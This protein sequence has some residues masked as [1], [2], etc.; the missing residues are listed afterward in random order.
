[1]TPDAEILNG[2]T[3]VEANESQARPEPA[4]RRAML[5]KAGMFLGAS[6]ALAALVTPANATSEGQ[7][8]G[9]DEIHGLWL[10]VVSAPDNSFP[11]F[12]VLELYGSGLYIGS[13]QPDMTPAALSSSLWAIYQRVGPRTFSLSGRFWTYDPSANPTGFAT[14][15]QVAVVSKDGKSYHAKGYAQFF[16]LNSNPLGPP[17]LQYDDGNRLA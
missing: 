9:P 6:S 14:V 8:T 11:P 12:Q 2:A 10:S 5:K 17:T 3:T 16:D 13:G 15:T 7:S 4:N 1:M